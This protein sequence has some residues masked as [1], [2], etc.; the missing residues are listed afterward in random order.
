MV[1]IGGAAPD[2][3]KREKK[4]NGLTLFSFLLPDKLNDPHQLQRHALHLS[5]AHSIAQPWSCQSLGEDVPP[6]H[7]ATQDWLQVYTHS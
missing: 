1:V 3:F 5:L 2:L 4:Y 6:R 7:G